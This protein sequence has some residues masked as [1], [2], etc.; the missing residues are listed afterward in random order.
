MEQAQDDLS[1]VCTGYMKKMCH[2]LWVWLM[3]P[4]SSALFHDHD[5]IHRLTPLMGLVQY[6]NWGNALPTLHTG[7][8][9]LS[10]CVYASVSVCTC[11]CYGH[12]SSSWALCLHWQPWEKKVHLMI[13]Q[14]DTSFLQWM[15]HPQIYYTACT[16]G[17]NQ[18]V[19]R[20]YIS[21]RLPDHS[22]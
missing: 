20:K 1:F 13:L 12:F 10:A 9:Y 6:M 16:I 18:L 14:Y 11:M 21:E 3:L 19:L 22:V 4:E 5:W 15:N 17:L 2:S 8:C 7:T